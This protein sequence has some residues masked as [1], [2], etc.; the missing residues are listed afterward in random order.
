MPKYFSFQKSYTPANETKKQCF[1][2]QVLVVWIVSVLGQAIT[3]SEQV[4]R[5]LI[6]LKHVYPLIGSA[7]QGRETLQ[8]T[9]NRAKVWYPYI[10]GSCGVHFRDISQH[11]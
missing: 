9:Q 10:L 11:N 5:V 4:Y 6:K 2:T 3:G 1:F 7:L 8:C